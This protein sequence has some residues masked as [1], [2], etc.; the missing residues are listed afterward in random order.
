MADA[1]FVMGSVLVVV[2]AALALACVVAQA[3]LARWWETSAGRHVFAFQ[4]ALAAVLTLWGLRVWIPDSGLVV[5]L[6]NAAFAAVPV[7]LAWRL[8]IIFRTWRSR[9]REHKRGEAHERA[10]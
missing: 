4:A 3:M 7:V 8:A 2:S 6:R 5:V 10:N 9:R 1:T